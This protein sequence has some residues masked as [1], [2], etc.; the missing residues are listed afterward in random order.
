MAAVDFTPS[1]SALLANWR[2]AMRDCGASDEEI[3]RV[4]EGNLNYQK[5]VDD[6]AISQHKC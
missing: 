5:E 6:A 1:S 2:E 3:R 4:E